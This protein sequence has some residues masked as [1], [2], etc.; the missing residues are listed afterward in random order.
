MKEQGNIYMKVGRKWH[1]WYNGV[2]LSAYTVKALDNKVDKMH[3]KIWTPEYID[4]RIKFHTREYEILTSKE[5]PLG[6]DGVRMNKY[7]QGLP[8]LISWLKSLS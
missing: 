3:S 2:D 8:K 1:C 7:I 5:I 4:K 6:E